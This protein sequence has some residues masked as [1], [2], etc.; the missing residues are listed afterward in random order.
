MSSLTH[1]YATRPRWL[2]P[3]SLLFWWHIFKIPACISQKVWQSINP[4]SHG[5]KQSVTESGELGGID[6][7]KVCDSLPHSLLNMQ[8]WSHMASIYQHPSPLPDTCKQCAKIKGTGTE[9]SKMCHKD[10]YSVQHYQW[11][12]SPWFACSMYNADDNCISHPHNN[13]SSYS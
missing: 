1:I 13:V 5:V 12:I 2:H 8:S 9:W 6:L 11:Q 3:W 4:P 10:R 7:N